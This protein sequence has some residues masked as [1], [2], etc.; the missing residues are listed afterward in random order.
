MP[1]THCDGK[2]EDGRGRQSIDCVVGQSSL[3][4]E[5]PERKLDSEIQSIW[6]QT[7]A[8]DPTLKVDHCASKPIS[9]SIEEICVLRD[10]KGTLQSREVG[11]DGEV[12]KWDGSPRFGSDVGVEREVRIIGNWVFRRC[13]CSCRSGFGL[14]RRRLILAGDA[15]RRGKAGEKGGEGSHEFG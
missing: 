14:P 8:S 9:S 10:R 4:P 13:R 7:E 15:G 12:G 11:V 3:S 5:N 6:G 2:E 1:N